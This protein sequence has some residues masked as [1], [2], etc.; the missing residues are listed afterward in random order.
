[1]SQVGQD[2]GAIAFGVPV[3][4]KVAGARVPVEIRAPVEATERSALTLTVPPVLAAIWP[5][6][7]L[8]RASCALVWCAS[9][10]QAGMA[11]RRLVAT[12]KAVM[13]VSWV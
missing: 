5:K 12:N 11:L 3:T 2:G 9:T 10:H 4:S 6:R 13:A 8:C 1:M 7:R